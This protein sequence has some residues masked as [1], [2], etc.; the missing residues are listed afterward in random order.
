[1]QSSKPEPFLNRLLFGTV[2]LAV[3][4]ILFVQFF[5]TL[6]SETASASPALNPA[7]EQAV[8]AAVSAQHPNAATAQIIVSPISQVKAWVFG[9]VAIIPQPASDNAPDEETA[10]RILLFFAEQSNGT[11]QVALEHSAA[12]EQA[13][14]QIPRN[15]LTPEQWSTMPTTAQLSGDGSMDL[16]LPWAVGET[17]WLTS[18]PHGISRA[19]L[20]FAVIGGRVRAAREGVAYT[21]CGQSSDLVRID[22]PG[23]FSTNYYHLSGIAVAN[24]TPVDRYTYIGMI[25]TGTRCLGSYVT[26]A[27]VHF[28]ISRGGTRIPIDGIDIGGWTVSALPGDFNGCMTRIRDGNRQCVRNDSNL[29]VIEGPG[30][31]TNEGATGSGNIKPNPPRLVSPEDGAI[32][33]TNTVTL[34]MEDAGDPDNGPRSWRDYFFIITKS[35]NSWRVESGWITSTSWTVEL[36]GEGSYTW[37]VHAGDGAAMSDPAPLRTFTY[38]P[39]RPPNPPHLISPEN[40]ATIR[41][42]SV[43]LQ[44]A[45]AGDPDN[46]PA[47]QRNYSFHIAKS[48]NSWRTDSGW[49]TS[50]SWTVQL[51][52]EGS[53]TW[54]VYAGDGAAMSDPAPLRT[55]TYTPNRPPNPPNLISPDHNATVNTATVTLQASD[56]G[57]PDNWP[58]SSRKFRFIITSSD[59]SWQANSGWIDSPSWTV[60]LPKIGVYS[61]YAQTNDG[62]ADS[63]SS[64]RR[65]LYYAV[66]APIPTPPPPPT[67]APNVWRVPYYS[68]YDP[69]WSGQMMNRPSYATDCNYTIGRIGCALTSLTMV[70][71]YYGVD[72]NP[73]TM[74]SCLGAHACPLYWSSPQVRTCTNNKLRWVKWP[75]FSYPNL[76][77]ELRKGPVILELQKSDGNMH[78][79][80]VLGGSGSN[81]AN[82]TV[83]DPG[84]RNGAYTTLANALSYWRNYRPSSMRIYTGTP[85]PLPASLAEEATDSASQAAEV[86]PIEPLAS[87][88]LL[89]G[90]TI[91]GAIAPYRNTS[92]EM[93]LELAAQSAAGT[94]TE[95][96]VW[97]NAE[98]S[99]IWQPFS[100]YVT[101]PLAGTYYVQFRDSAGNTSVVFSTGLPQAR[102]LNIYTTFIP[103]TA[104]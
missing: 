25:G 35:D 44:V 2:V 41:T 1:M 30:L 19:A 37:T 39:N 26:G 33:R 43:T 94:V 42:A 93:V 88:P 7:L 10:P 13:L 68:Q 14:T 56:G 17:W 58:N 79:I 52:G 9:S 99:N 76:E 49:I 3:T 46:W 77:A 50:T 22:H 55:F 72:H 98:Q 101:A 85:A 61:W 83:H 45:D 84:L 75:A 20:D 62:A 48:D 54:T 47:P 100:R 70:A 86:D 97:T 21:P 96:R 29:N 89:N 63:A 8:S 15:L 66:V 91:T 95:M 102:R 12:F 60:Q 24:G 69:R 31:I 87:P 51:P 78:F 73:G 53:Y 23:G 32:I 36:P 90:T 28:W 40:G 18:G 5:F 11:W 64:S 59:N 67:P 34:H 65:T 27:H 74:N 81:P 4:S 57:D 92:T 38:I 103:M 6:R 82:Y 71:R 16:N 80:V 104:R